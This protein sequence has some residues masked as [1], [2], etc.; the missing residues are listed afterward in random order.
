MLASGWAREG[1]SD[2]SRG[3]RE[4]VR[5][6]IVDSCELVS[7][8]LIPFAATFEVVLVVQSAAYV[9]ATGEPLADVFPF[10]TR[11]TESDD[12]RIL[13]GTPFGGLLGW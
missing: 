2:G 3:R 11:A 9:A 12:L 10:H 13:R 7:L 5:V 6:P 1:E 4:H 8:L